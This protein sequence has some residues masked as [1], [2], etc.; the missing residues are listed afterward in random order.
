M[1]VPINAE[2]M[3]VLI[4]HQYTSQCIDRNL[5]VALGTVLLVDKVFISPLDC[6]C[7]LF[8]AVADGLIIMNS[9]S[10]LTCLL[11]SFKG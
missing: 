6:L 8:L 11:T 2:S 5:R 4:L 3:E 9:I 7:I 1:G 10:L